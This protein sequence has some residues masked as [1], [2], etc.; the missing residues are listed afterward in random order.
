[1]LGLVVVPFA[2]ENAFLLRL[3]PTTMREILKWSRDEL[4]AEMVHDIMMG[5]ARPV[6]FGVQVLVTNR[7]LPLADP[8]RAGLMEHLQHLERSYGVY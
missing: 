4:D 2:T 1:M 7:V 6:I 3:H 8:T 5:Q